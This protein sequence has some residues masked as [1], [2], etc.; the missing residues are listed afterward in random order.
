M[1]PTCEN[2]HFARDISSLT[3]VE[4]RRFPPTITK[5]EDLSVTT[6]FPLTLKSAWCGEWHTRA[7]LRKA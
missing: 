4:C 6:Y 5:A 1:T 2:C 7:K 3:A